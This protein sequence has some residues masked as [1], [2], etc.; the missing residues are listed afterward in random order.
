M[1]T[2]WPPSSFSAI[3]MPSS[4]TK[5]CGW[6]DGWVGG[7]VGGWVVT[8]VWRCLILFG[9]QLHCSIYEERVLLP[10]STHPLL[11]PSH[12]A[13]LQSRQQLVL[14]LVEEQPLELRHV[15]ALRG[16]YDAAPVGVMLALVVGVIETNGTLSTIQ[17]PHQPQLTQLK[18]NHTPIDPDP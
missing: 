7:W 2:G 14:G 15:G 6:M 10:P 9:C 5:T 1:A 8:G 18:A 3:S 12:P 13:H 17:H 4:V 16:L 11:H